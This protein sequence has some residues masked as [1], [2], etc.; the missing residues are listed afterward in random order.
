MAL[1]IGN[2]NYDLD[3]LKNP[4]NDAL[5]MKQTLENIGFEVLLDT[6]LNTRADLLRSINNFGQKRKNYNIGLVYY[7]GHG[8]QI[9]GNNY[10][11]A[12]KEKYENRM[13]VEDNGVNVSRIVDFFEDSQDE[14]NI[15]ILD[16]CRNNPF[17]KQWTA[18]SRAFNDGLGLAPISSSGSVVAFSTSAGTTAADGMDNSGNSVYC[19]SLVKNITLPDTDL[20]QVFRNVRGEVMFQSKGNQKPTCENNYIGSDFYFVKNNFTDIII[21]ID[22][23]IENDNFDL[24]RE[25]VITILTKSPNHKKALLRKGRIEYLENNSVYNGEDLFLADSLYPNDIEVLEYIARYYSTVGDF[26]NSIKSIELAIKIDN[27]ASHLYYWKARFYFDKNLIDEALKEITN[28]ILYDETNIEFIELRAE[29]FIAKGEF[30]NAL[31]D[32]NKTIELS[33]ES[34]YYY[35]NRADFFIYHDVN[36]KK[37]IE[38][39]NVVLEIVSDDYQKTRAFN[40]LGT[41]YE[42]LQDY[43]LALK[44]FSQ[45]IETYPNEPVPYSNRA[46]IYSE[47]TEFN[48]AILD[49]SQAIELD[50]SNSSYYE[51]R[52]NCFA[53]I[54]DFSKALY[55]FDMTIELSPE[56][57]YYNN[58]AD[59]YADS[60]QEYEKALA[61]YEKSIEIES[62]DYEKMRALNNRAL[63]YEEQG[64]Y[65]SAINEYTRAIEFNQF[66]PIPYSNR[67]DI[68]IE[69]GE[70]D[71]AI[72][73]F[74]SAIELDRNNPSLYE[75]RANCF[76]AMGN[77]KKALDD[78]N[79]AIELSQEDSYYYNNRA[80]FFI[81]HDE[82]DKNAIKDC[83]IAIENATDD[84]EK[85]RAFNNLGTIYE[86]SQDYELALKSFS[87]AIEAFPNEPVLYSNR[88]RIYSELTEFDMSILDYSKAI[89]LDP[90]NDDYYYSRAEIYDTYLNKQYD[91]LVD[92]SLS[93]HYDST[94][95]SNWFARGLLFYNLND[96][97]SAISDFKQILLIDS[98]DVAALNWLGVYYGEIGEDSLEL[99]YFSK[100]IS[101]APLTFEDSLSISWSYN[102][103]AYSH[104]KENNNEL[105]LNNYNHSVQLDPENILRYY[106]R[107]WFNALYLK[108]YSNSILDFNTAIQLEP[109]NANLYLQRAKINLLFNEYELANKDFEIAVKKSNEDPFYIAEIANFYSVKGDIKKADKNF[110]NALLLDSSNIHTLR[111]KTS[112]LMRNKLWQEALLNST[113]A[114]E[115]NNKDTLSYCQLGEIYIQLNEIQKSLNAFQIAEKIHELIDG[116]GSNESDESQIFLSDIQFKIFELYTTLN[117][118]ELACNYI[119]KAI[120]SLKNETRCN[121]NSIMD[122]FQSNFTECQ[123]KN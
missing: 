67:G 92:Y 24:A 64:D 17:E 39:C 74:N 51:S 38:D 14:L 15:L 118:T 7:A 90:K 42:Y 25:K 71:L 12:T 107:G 108:D 93:I 83:N 120:D 77:N 31:V 94:D 10:L 115:L 1:V 117:E 80:E 112:H 109:E 113:M 85:M 30:E 121:K 45:A 16:A 55:D 99:F 96:Y 58:R 36:H 29:C 20:D 27:Q 32:L 4:V 19:L 104:Q 65:K 66:E 48:M 111:L 5:L 46:R 28:A 49:Y 69:I 72:K 8:V 122:K 95:V 103:L 79:M 63:I 105:S 60:L 35:N 73:D 43:E 123:N 26:D 98:N 2:G 33:P 21:E 50:R 47:L 56:S 78:L 91:A 9:N 34:S 100:T 75:L 11:L 87:Q 110:E 82:N 102:N 59:F 76:I 53:S 6:N 116:F 97:K 70:F 22:S 37:A 88:A 106:E 52:A 62:D 68:Y 57:N 81:D 61:D 18:A 44:W 40:N 86:Y 23:L 114:I 89:E 54:G 3:E 119:Q 13:D 41:I 101:K 84:Y